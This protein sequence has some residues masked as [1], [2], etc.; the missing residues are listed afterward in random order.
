MASFATIALV[1]AAF[2]ATVSACT[3]PLLAAAK[4]L[5]SEAV[6]PRFSLSRG[7]SAVG[8]GSTTYIGDASIGTR[9]IISF[10]VENSGKTALIIDASKITLTMGSDT[11]AGT[12]SL[13]TAPSASISADGDS[14]LEI[15][16]APTVTGTKSAIVTLATNDVDQAFFSF[17]ISGNGVDNAKDMTAFS[18]KG[19]TSTGSV[20]SSTGTISDG[21]IAL[22]MLYGTDVSDLVATFETSGVAVL[23]GANAQV[24]GTTANDFG[25]PVTYIVKAADGTTKN[26][27]VTV[28]IGKNS[29]ASLLSFGLQSPMAT[30]SISDNAISVSIPSGTDKTDLVATFT[31][32]A[33]ATVKVGSVVQE[34]GITVNNFSS[35]VTYDV[36]SEDGSATNHYTIRVLLSSKEITSFGL[37]NPA[38]TANISG[39]GIT[40]TVPYGTNLLS[41]VA[42]FATTGASVS[43][44]GVA[45]VSGATA[46]SFASARTYTVTAED[47]STKAYT[48]TLSVAANT[49]KE[50]TGFGFASPAVY[51]TV[52]SG[53]TSIALGVPYETDLTKLVAIFTTTGASV[54]VGAILQTSGSNINDF[55][56][57]LSYVVAASDGETQTYVVTVTKVQGA[58]VLSS[59]GIGTIG[60]D[61]AV[62]TC[63]ITSSGGATI[64]ASGVC[65]GTSSDPTVTSNSFSTDGAAA[66][67]SYQS[68][69]TGLAPGTLYYARAYATNSVGTSYGSQT[70]FRTLPAAPTAP[71]ISVVDGPAGSGELALSWSVVTG[72]AAYDL[73]YSES[74]T[75]P[76]GQ[77][78]ISTASTSYTVSGLTDF[79]TYYFWIKAR[80]V[81]GSSVASP[82]ASGSPGV[83]VAGISLLPSSVTI[84]VGSTNQI[85]ATVSPANAT[86]PTVTWASSSTSVATVTSSGLVA[87]VAPG[88][89]T[90]TATSSAT[91]VGNVSKS[92]TC[93]INVPPAA[94]VANTALTAEGGQVVLS[95][96]ASTGATSYNIYYSTSS[97]AG[98]S[99]TKV[100]GITATTYTLSDLTNWSTYYFVVTAV[101]TGG[102][103]AA[104]NQLSCMPIRQEIIV[105]NT[106]TNSIDFNLFNASSGSVTRTSGHEYIFGPNGSGATDYPS[107]VA[108]DPNARNAMYIAYAGTAAC[109]ATYSYSASGGYATSPYTDHHCD[110]TGTE[111]LT[112]VT[113]PSGKKCIYVAYNAQAYIIMY[114]IDA[115]GNLSTIHTYTNARVDSARYLSADPSGRFLFASNYDAS[116][117]TSYSIDSATGH[118]TE[119]GYVASGGSKPYRSAVTPDGG[120]L[121]V[122]NYGSGNVVSFA[123]NSSTGVL[124]QQSS[125]ATSGEGPTGIAIDAGG[126]NVYVCSARSRTNPTLLLG[127]VNHFTFS[128]GNLAGA[129][130]WAQTLYGPLDIALDVTGTRAIVLNASV[131][132][133]SYGNALVYPVDVATGAVSSL[134]SATSFVTG[135]TPTHLIVF[136]LP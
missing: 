84:P 43:V 29:A 103:S 100:S 10:S 132:S 68:S 12:F 83:R 27:V 97:G 64:T 53:A 70:T 76:V 50:I 13:E 69:I 91:A 17:T 95:W 21:T 56:N 52:P 99:G 54:K 135:V 65:W 51:V 118:L 123:I 44:D 133:Y 90:V 79:S 20:V 101:G 3:N 19:S 66:A 131:G 7:A 121:L 122:V 1:I 31:A 39:S 32:S 117:V 18:L 130:D 86:Y 124:T 112:V 25:S 115:S 127:Y 93:A 4:S 15:A 55:S 57:P 98:T 26:Y 11:E 28:T 129:S 102:E 16:F 108:I 105:A 80:N 6:S 110:G 46:N 22:T 82:S 47:G 120:Y 34:S 128:G 5:Q 30:G 74:S 2:A 72:A 109:F 119:S 37:V 62:A 36:V 73:Y 67:A 63:E 9:Q 134:S 40:L 126:G 77:T 42:T 104:S 136:K 8:S 71:A 45:Q 114:D 113:T 38:V 35:P 41:L 61:S 96:S 78:P 58:P 107:S 81:S 106:V 88:T 85:T 48:V 23:V 75:F 24:S 60:I 14:I 49:A 59:C 111:H 89:A 116:R 92:A 33:G 125:I 94:P 87:A